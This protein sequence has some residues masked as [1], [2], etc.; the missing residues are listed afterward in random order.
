MF[1]LEKEEVKLLEFFSDMV[2]Y[3]DNCVDGNMSQKD[4]LEGLAFSILSHLDGCSG[5]MYRVIPA[6]EDGNHLTY[7]L[8]NS[9]NGCL[10]ERFYEVHRSIVDDECC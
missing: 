6:I 4:R 2:N 9:I 10:H 1:N 3:W 5:E 7:S 8:N